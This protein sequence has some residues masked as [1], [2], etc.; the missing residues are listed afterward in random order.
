MNRDVVMRRVLVV[1]ALFNFFVV[2]IVLFPDTLGRFADLPVPVSRFYTWLLALFIGLFGAAYAWL[3][4]RPTIDR[5]LVALATVGKIG[6]FVVALLCWQLGDIS[7]KAFGPAIV[8]LLFALIFLW[9]LRANP[10]A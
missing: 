2:V 4:R 6:V 9:W 10:R 8:D 3:S 7:A 1:G 5:P